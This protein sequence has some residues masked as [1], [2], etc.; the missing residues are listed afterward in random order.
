VTDC[1]SCNL[2]PSDFISYTFTF[3]LGLGDE[4]I[5]GTSANV[6]TIAGGAALEAGSGV[7]SYFDGSVIELFTNA[8]TSQAVV[9]FS[10]LGPGSIILDA[11]FAEE[12]GQVTLPFRI[13]T[14][15]AV[16][17]PIAGAGL[18]GLI[19]ACGGL[20]GWWRRRQKIA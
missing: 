16:P 18:P 12:I 5:T 7:I 17:G 11:P 13:A 1:D 20:L 10:Q 6:L 2:A 15:V 19:A 3:D 8:T 9:S 14:E 4:S